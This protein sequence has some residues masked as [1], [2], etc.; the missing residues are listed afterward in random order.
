MMT[1]KTTAFLALSLILVSIPVLVSFFAVTFTAS[2]DNIKTN[3]GQGDGSS[4]SHISN[5]NNIDITSQRDS[6]RDSTNEF[7]MSKRPEFPSHWG[8]P[9]LI[10][11]RD[12]VPLP[13]PYGR[14]SGT[15]KKWIE[16][17]MAE[18]R[19]AAS[20]GTT[21]AN[22]DHDKL[23]WPEQTLVGYNGE[24]AKR[25]ILRS[26]RH[27]LLEEN[28][29]ILPQDAMVTMDYREDR[30]RIFVDDDGKVVRQPRLG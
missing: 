19:A 29:H 4:S 9:P 26:D 8:S 25:I 1:T 12:L 24:E 23:S 17:K 27:K 11:T 22:D 3:L 7:F 13:S 16:S 6:Q 15:L 30:V 10:Q 18:D 5:N 2:D 21:D 28:V 14:G 20:A